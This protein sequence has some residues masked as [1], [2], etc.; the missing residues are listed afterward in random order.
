MLKNPL[1]LIRGLF[2]TFSVAIVAV[3]FGGFAV[4]GLF[5]YNVL[6]DLPEV[7]TLKD[8]HH[9]VATEV[10][11]ED[12]RKIG[13]FT[14]ER[15]YPVKFDTIPKHVIYAFI[16][17]EDS[18]FFEHGGIDLGGVLRAVFS[19]VLRGRYAQ[20][21][22]TITQQVARTMLLTRKKELTRKIREMVL[23]HRM[24]QQ[25]TKNEILG[26]YLSEIYL[27]H[28]AFG[29]GA[30]A[31][32]YFHK[33]V[34]QLTIAEAAILAGL[35]QRPNEWNP[36]RN[37][38]LAKRR[39]QYV[40]HRM[41][42]D[43]FIT[44][45]QQRQALGET[46]KLYE[47]ADASTSIAP[48]FLEYVRVYLMNK[49]G[50]DKVLTTG[51]KVY[52]TVNY[53][54]Q[55]VAEQSVMHGLHE[56]DK[57]LGW[58]GVSQH[59]DDP[60]KAKE[61][62][63]GIHDETL[64]KLAPARILPATIDASF[65]KL[66][67]DLTQFSERNNPY[68]GAT[69]VKQGEIYKALITGI[70]A[71]RGRTLAD[72]GQT[73][74]TLPWSYMEWT[75]N[76]DKPNAQNSDTLRM[77]DVIY[78]KVEKIDRGTGEIEV[79]L[80]QD[81]EVQA[82]LL[83]F[84]TET[85]Y[86][87]AMVGGKSFEL[88]KFNCA[89]QAKRQV[90]STG[91]PLLYAAAMDKGFSPASLVTDAPIVFK[92]EGN[93]DADNAGEDW[94]PHNYEGKF[95]GDIPL[96]L[97]LVRSMNIPTVKLL[98]E[99]TIDYDIQYARNLGITAVLPRDLSIALG[100][101]STTLEELTRTYAV[102]PR[103]GR[104]LTLAYIKKVQDEKGQ[105]LEEFMP[106]TDAT[107]PKIPEGV[108]PNLAQSGLVMSPQTA[109][110]MID[111]MKGVDRE[112]TGRAATAV[113]APVAGK[114]GTTSDHRD[115][116]F[117]GY[118]PHVMTGVWVGY[119]K[120]KPLDPAETGGRAAAPIWVQYMNAAI[121]NYPRNDFAIPDDIVFAYIDRQT[122]KLANSRDP[123]RVRVAFK[124][125]TVPNATGDNVPRI[126][127]P[128]S[129][130]TSTVAPATSVG[131]APQAGQVAAPPVPEKEDTSDSLRQGYQD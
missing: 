76:A 42:E 83:S 56:V 19:N 113:P 95:E 124:S 58:R 120:D 37:P 84:E 14:T 52:T 123:N 36:F 87:R 50:S 129:R 90:G 128:G 69:P 111:M 5:L 47:V 31:Q 16:A 114:T 74:V 24:E 97:A 18:H 94:R 35:P 85:G 41:V 10:F 119:E 70:D 89:L 82:A 105:T 80:E 118:T 13:E 86:V 48:Y 12:G 7:S 20:G 126:G 32:N 60:T 106:G 15:R 131:T 30:A 65:R 104:P 9:A 71:K 93:L 117:L 121:Q 79:S 115:A 57:R 63:A 55:R 6:K 23:A 102:F 64:D 77:G 46:L 49:Y 66:Q 98:N 54:L 109:Y 78:A 116:W 62:L 92:Y 127:E 67:Y 81:P 2:Q 43:K 125:G 25:L 96:R 29:I 51:M 3:I 40:L 107:K 8:F 53:D 75:R 88:S 112:G 22:S 1:G 33:T 108:A 99:I 100:S 28:G 61:F 34:D 4:A 130:M 21:G 122:G 91:K 17:A 59:F 103:L 72:I 45:A 11:A 110:V 73:H 39:Q 44:D 68:F 27:G 26:L 101:W 38:Y